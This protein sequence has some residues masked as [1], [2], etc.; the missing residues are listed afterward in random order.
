MTF[1]VH[2]LTL[3]QVQE[4]VFVIYIIIIFQ[5]Y[6][7]SPLLDYEVL[8]PSTLEFQL[9]NEIPYRSDYDSLCMLRLLHY[10]SVMRLFLSALT[11]IMP[12]R[13]AHWDIL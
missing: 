9:I 2:N 1:L 13:V 11:G 4:A 8:Y 10:R 12:P 3:L 5:H 6:I 7:G